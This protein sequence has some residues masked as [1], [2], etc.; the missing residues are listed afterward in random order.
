M[1]HSAIGV[2]TQPSVRRLLRTCTNP[3][4]SPSPSGTVRSTNGQRGATIRM[5]SGL[6]CS[7]CIFA[8]ARAASSSGEDSSAESY[9]MMSS[10]PARSEG[11][12]GQQQQRSLQAQ[13]QD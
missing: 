3:A 12:W 2:T 13:Q 9:R 1:E 11:G 10:M 8:A 4:G 6:R 5:E 7:A